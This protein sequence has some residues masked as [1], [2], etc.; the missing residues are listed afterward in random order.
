[1]ELTGA[2]WRMQ[3]T[4][5]YGTIHWDRL[6]KDACTCTALGGMNLHC[7]FQPPMEVEMGSGGG[8]APNR[9]D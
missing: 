3:S 7:L 9:Y 2:V 1:M 5:C 4:A 6:I 8:D